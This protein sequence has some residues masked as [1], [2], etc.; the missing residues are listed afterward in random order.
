MHGGI[1]PTQSYASG[2]QRHSVDT[3][4]PIFR[5][6]VLFD[7]AGLMGVDALPADF[8]VTPE[9]LAACGVETCGRRRSR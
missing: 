8:V 9:H 6:G 1:V 5:P 2:V 4:A 7:V 3:I